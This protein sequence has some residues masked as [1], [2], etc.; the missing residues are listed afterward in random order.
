MTV[1]SFSIAMGI[2]R[3]GFQLLSLTSVVP[4]N[5]S[6][7][8][9]PVSPPLDTPCLLPDQLGIYLYVYLGLALISLAVLFVFHVSWSGQQEQDVGWHRQMLQNGSPRHSRS[10]NRSSADDDY[11]CE[12]P[13]L[14]PPA[15]K[16]RYDNHTFTRSRGRSW[17]SWTWTFKF[18]NQRRRITVPLLPCRARNPLGFRKG[19]HIR[20][21]VMFRAFVKD[22]FNVAIPP[23][24]AFLLAAWWSTHE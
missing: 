16:S 15:T 19:Q 18:G 3:P 8:Q 21:H 4:S 9:V 10:D 2:R 12:Y 24:C 13:S 14:P 6:L 7:T 17:T 1:K 22:V 20:Q 11:N 5:K 23:L